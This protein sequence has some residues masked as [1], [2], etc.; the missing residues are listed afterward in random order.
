MGNRKGIEMA[1]GKRKCL[2]VE[3]HNWET[4]GSQQQLQFVLATARQFF[5]SGTKDRTITVRVFV[6]PALSAP[7][8]NKTITIS[9]E[10]ANGSRRTNGFPEMGA[11]P[12]SFVFFEETA[13][14][15]VY[16]VWWLVD[17]VP[18]AATYSGWAR[19]KDTQYGRGRYSV[20]VNAPAPRR[21]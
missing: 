8:F 14:A 4:G 21:A 3:R 13:Q 18:I 11:V 7:S 17:K 10:Y 6:N 20:V 2:I 12:S 19:G 15:D 9:R 1:N 16:D 5:G